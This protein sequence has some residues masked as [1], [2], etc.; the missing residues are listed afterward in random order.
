MEF[1]PAAR[2]RT[3]H[4]QAYR[5]ATV[6][7]SHHERSR[8]AILATR[9]V[10][11]VGQHLGRLSMGEVVVHLAGCVSMM[12]VSTRVTRLLCRCL[13]AHASRRTYGPPRV[14][15][16]FAWC[17]STSSSRLLYARPELKKL[18]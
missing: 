16:V 12:E 17:L 10:T 1:G 11:V 3:P 18:T 6:A 9:L 8:A 13:T 4:Q 2:A 7:E 15:H 5:F 14:V